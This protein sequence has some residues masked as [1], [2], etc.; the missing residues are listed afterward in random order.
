MRYSFNPSSPDTGRGELY[1]SDLQLK[2]YY[3]HKK[4]CKKVIH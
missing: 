3:Y 4:N 2:L 1:I